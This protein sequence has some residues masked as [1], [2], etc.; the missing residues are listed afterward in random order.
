VE[1]ARHFCLR[2]E[3]PNNDLFVTRTS[4][5]PPG[6]FGQFPKVD[7]HFR[8]RGPSV[9]ADTAITEC[10]EKRKRGELKT[11]K[12]VVECSNPKVYAAWKEAGDPNLDL[13]NVLLAARLV[14]AENVDSGRIRG[15]FADIA[16]VL[17][18]CVVT[19]L[20]RGKHRARSSGLAGRVSSS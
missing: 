13:L 15:S 7:V 18:V 1:E 14:G 16:G 4:E 5:V 6:L 17:S 12:A 9:T 8:C 2:Q 3:G 10:N 20:N 11:F 19:A